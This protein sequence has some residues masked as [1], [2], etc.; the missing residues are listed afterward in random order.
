MVFVFYITEE[1]RLK[2]ESVTDVDGTDIDLGS[3]KNCEILAIGECTN[4]PRFAIMKLPSIHGLALRIYT[5]GYYWTCVFKI[6][7]VV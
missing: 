1:C 6:K 4:L 2:S 3:N 7:I 5:G